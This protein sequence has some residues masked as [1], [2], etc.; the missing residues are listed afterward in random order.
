MQYDVQLLEKKL[1]Y[2]KIDA[3]GDELMINKLKLI[4]KASKIDDEIVEINATLETLKQEIKELEAQG[5]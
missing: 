2:K 1:K 3:H 5:E 4:E